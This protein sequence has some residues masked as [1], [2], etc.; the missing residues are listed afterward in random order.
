MSSYPRVL[1]N[2]STASAAG[3]VIEHQGATI[4][5]ELVTPATAAAWLGNVYE[6]QRPLRKR[7]VE[8]YARDMA[9]GR[10]GFSDAAICFDVDG[11][12]IQGQH[13]CH[14]CVES[15]RS[16][17]SIIVRGMPSDTYGVLDQGIKRSPTDV[18]RSMGEANV[19]TR[20]AVARLVWC[21]R[22]DDL[23]RMASIAV[24]TPEV[25]QVSLSE[26]LMGEACRVAD[27]VRKSA[28]IKS[29]VAGASF[30]ITKERAPNTAAWFFERLVDGVG[31]SENEP[32][33]LLR[34]RMLKE[35]DTKGHLPQK[36]VMAL[37]LKAWNYTVKGQAI[38][39]LRYRNVGPAAEAYPVP[40]FPTAEE[41]AELEGAA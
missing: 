4:T 24:S 39:T 8:K 36:D 11:A 26:P 7:Q 30:I 17:Y 13:R 29:S 32:V 27:R 35:K 2:G 3:G 34:E 41:D 1:R 38:R 31:L 5:V 12:M 25:V 28:G 23:S 14:A 40:L 21:Y 22:N 18:L 16:F 37:V 33:R 15:G 6:G 19:A 10:W 9:A 20:A